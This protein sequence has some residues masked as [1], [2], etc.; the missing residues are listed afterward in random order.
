MKIYQVEELV[1]ITK[2]NIRFYEEEG[3]LNPERDPLNGYRDYTLK[4]VQQLKKIKLLRKLSVPIEDIRLLLKGKRS[5]EESMEEQIK[6][7]EKQQKNTELMKDFCLRL[8]NEVQ[9][10]LNQSGGDEKSSS[11]SFFIH[12]DAEKYLSEISRLEAGGSKFMDVKKEDISRKKKVGAIFAAGF[13]LALMVLVFASVL[14]ALIHTKTDFM[15]FIILLVILG[16]FIIGIVTALILRLK[17]INK[18]EE[19]EALKY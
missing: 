10:N 6:R 9:N 18:G 7:L 17:E 8:K 15:P 2:K 11:K 12:L 4:D 16:C 5:F 13:F 1:G 3:L 19:I 14:I